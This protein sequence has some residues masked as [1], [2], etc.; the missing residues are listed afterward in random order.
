[1]KVIAFDVNETLLDMAG[2]DGAFT[3]FFG[4]A[5]A[6]KEWFAEVQKL[7]LTSAATG[8]FT[9][10][11]KITHAALGVLVERYGKAADEAVLNN[12]L[13]S[14]AHLPAHSDVAS[15]LKRLKGEKYTVVALGNNTGEAIEAQ[16]RNAG[17]W[18]QFDHIFGSELTQQYKPAK[19][20]YR[21]VARTLKCDLAEVLM[22]AAH[23][24][25]CAGAVHAGI[26]AAFVQRPGQVLDVLVPPL[27][28][29][30]RDLNDLAE[31]IATGEE[32]AA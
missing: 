10:F 24:W 4:S 22:V 8:Y 9:P 23:A 19:E 7:F 21:F 27:R 28:Y 11:S 29:N 15:A 6:R 13:A 18:E 1:M 12:I 17:I 2:L 31:Q 3:S 5:S 26:E 16:F 14:A 32:Q 30:V 25:D 20:P